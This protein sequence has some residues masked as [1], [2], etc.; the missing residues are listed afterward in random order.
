MANG[1]CINKP[2]GYITNMGNGNTNTGR[3]EMKTKQEWNRIWSH[4]NRMQ[5]SVMD[6]KT[7]KKEFMAK[8]EKERMDFYNW[9]QQQ[10]G[11]YACYM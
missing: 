11:Q 8:S 3:R 4:F 1:G 7:T 6:T 9:M 5:K 2:I 10:C